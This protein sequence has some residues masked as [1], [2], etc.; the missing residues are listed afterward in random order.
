[1]KEVIPEEILKDKKLAKWVREHGLMDDKSWRRPKNPYHSLIRS[2]IYQQVSGKAAAT[3]LNKFK[4][5]FGGKFPTP[6]QV[7]AKSE[8]ELRSA[9]LSRAKAVYVRDLAAKFQDG[10]IEPRK[11]PK[12]TNDEIIE[13]LTH[14]KG[15]GVWTAHMFL[16]FTLRRPDILPTLDLAIKKGFQEVYGLRKLPT[17]E[18][19]EKLA[20]GWR[21]HASTASLYLWRASENKYQVTKSTRKQTSDK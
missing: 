6:Q 15:I 7:L 20:R 5:L 2:I 21:A 8:T 18:Q 10:T 1:M 12:M 16:L 9:G 4:N 17:H 11:F 3:I 19:M 13:H 14:V